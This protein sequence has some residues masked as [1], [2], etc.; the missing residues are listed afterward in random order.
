MRAAEAM[1]RSVPTCG[2]TEA[3]AD[4][5][6]R[7]GRDGMC[8]VLNEGRV[9]LGRLRLD[10]LEASDRR[11]A[12][13]AMEPGPATIRADADLSETRERM[14]RRGAASLLVTTP[15]GVLLGLL[16]ADGAPVSG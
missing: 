8:V 10:R 12:E 7:T 3:V 15:D 1:E 9:V 14:Q 5:L 16:R 6:A 11:P 13:A 2:R 4:V